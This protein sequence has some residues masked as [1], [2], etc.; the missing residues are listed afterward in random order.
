MEYRPKQIKKD[1]SFQPTQ[2]VQSDSTFYITSS[3]KHSTAI[4]KVCSS[5]LSQV[6]SADIA[7][8]TLIGK[9]SCIT[10]AITVCEV[11]KRQLPELEQET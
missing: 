8:V 1:H 4:N 10:K 9:K 7:T 5:L 11:I 3:T 6:K 2:D